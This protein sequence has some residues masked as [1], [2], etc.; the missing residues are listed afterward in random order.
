MTNSQPGILA[1]V[2]ADAR[3]LT[4]SLLPDSDPIEALEALA[5]LA[6]DDSIVV[7]L[8]PS[9]L[10]AVGT[11]LPGMRSFPAMVGAGVEVPSTPTALWCWLRGDDR[12]ELLH[13]TRAVTTAVETAFLLEDVIDAF[14][15]GS[16]LDLSGYEDGTENP[17]GDAAEQA[18]L[19]REAGPGMDGGSFVAVQQWMHDLD[20]FMALEPDQ[21]DNVIGRRIADNEELEF[22]PESAHVKRTAQEDF[23]PEAF[24]LRRSMPWSDA[25]REGLVFVAFGKSFDAFE[26]LMKRM[27]GLDDG[28]RD[29]LFCF[30]RPVTGAYF[31]CPPV[32]DGRLDL[33]RLSG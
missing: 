31:W 14:R 7:G 16:G 30:T 5:E 9:L 15:F 22:A 1:P 4:F 33:S 27:V 3:Y 18:G 21:R 32:K 25:A 17:E 6:V 24:V 11:E 12:G 29:E 13:C 20:S 2:P 10:A 28:I 23:E 26:A 19:I 8:G